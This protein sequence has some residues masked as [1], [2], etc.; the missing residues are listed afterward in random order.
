MMGGGN[1]RPNVAGLLAT[2]LLTLS[3]A[4]RSPHR[5][6]IS[7]PA[8]PSRRLPRGQRDQQHCRDRRPQTLRDL[9][10]FG[11]G[12]ADR[13]AAA[14]HPATADGQRQRGCFPNAGSTGCGGWG[15]GAGGP[16]WEPL[17]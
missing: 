1:C 4:Q 12:P 2:L 10:A 6:I 7:S 8:Q 16:L 11:G 9:H 14:R 3:I 13:G 17:G 5:A 15:S